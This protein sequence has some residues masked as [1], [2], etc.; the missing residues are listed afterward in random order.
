VAQELTIYVLKNGRVPGTGGKPVA[1][2]ADAKVLI[3][4]IVASMSTAH[5]D[6]SI[7]KAYA[8]KHVV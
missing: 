1:L 5:L 7:C 8:N 2:E 6:L 3:R 4:T